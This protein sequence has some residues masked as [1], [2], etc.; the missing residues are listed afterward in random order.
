MLSHTTSDA[1]KI[2]RG[3]TQ[4]GQIEARPFVWVMVKVLICMQ[5]YRPPGSIGLT[6]SPCSDLCPHL[7]LC[8]LF[9]ISPPI[10]PLSSPTFFFTTIFLF[11]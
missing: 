6:L 8:P 7:P 3:G 11:L 1:Y 9:L 2:C 10:F 5:A 4:L